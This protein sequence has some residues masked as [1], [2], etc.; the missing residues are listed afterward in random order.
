M[1]GTKDSASGNGSSS[2]FGNGA[3]GD[4]SGGGSNGGHDF[5]TDPKGTSTGAA[6]RDLLN[7]SRPQQANSEGMGCD[8]DSIPAGG[9]ILLADPSAVSQKVGGPVQSGVPFK[10]LK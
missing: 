10:N 8:P 9:R 4:A 5:V 7:T 1:A 3:G 2:P 6:P